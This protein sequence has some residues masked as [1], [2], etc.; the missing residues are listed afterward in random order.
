MSPPRSRIG[1]FVG[2]RFT[3]AA[4]L[5][6]ARLQRKRELLRAL[7]AVDE[8]LRN[9][10]VLRGSGDLPP[11]LVAQAVREALAGVRDRM[12]RDGALPA[13][14]SELDAATELQGVA[15]RWVLE[16]AL[17]RIEGLRQSLLG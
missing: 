10:A 14:N 6:E 3:E 9:E 17:A 7:P 4:R 12:L 1:G 15:G 2:D 5:S 8:L 11:P 16:A 13:S